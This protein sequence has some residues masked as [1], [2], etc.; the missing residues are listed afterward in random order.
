MIFILLLAWRYYE[1]IFHYI[2]IPHS[3]VVICWYHILL[4]LYVDT[5]FY[6]C[7]MLIPQSTV[8]ICWYHSLL[9]SVDTTVYCCYMLIP[10]S[11]VVICWY[12]KLLVLYMLIPDV[13][14]S[15]CVYV[16]TTNLWFI[17]RWYLNPSIHY[18][19]KLN[20]S[21]QKS[22]GKHNFKRE[23]RTKINLSYWYSYFNHEHFLL[24][25]GWD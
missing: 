14:C 22:Y 5:T 24:L 13:H 18:I 2:L 12:H 7:Y 4:L 23:I 8:V 9:L 10:Q 3:T 21:W 16:D 11:T 25:V 15:L 20:H 6:C 1:C 19:Q 17:A